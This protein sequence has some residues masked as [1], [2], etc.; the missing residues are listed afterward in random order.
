MRVEIKASLLALA[1]ASVAGCGSTTGA[2]GGPPIAEWNVEPISR[3]ER[4]DGGGRRSEGLLRPRTAN[5]RAL[6]AEGTGRFIGSSRGRSGPSDPVNEEGVTLN[7]ANLPIPQAAK[8]VVGDILGADFVVD[9]KLDGKVTIHTAN[10]VRKSAALDLFQSALRVAGASVVKSGT[11]Y[12]IVPSDQAAISGEVIT[13]DSTPLDAAQFGEGA[14]VVQLRYVSAAEMKRVLEPIA[15]RGAIVRADDA[16][17]TLTLTGAPQDLATLQDAI[18]MFDID[19]MK[20]MSFALVPVR[21]GDADLLADDL[22]NVFGSEKEGPMGGMIRFIGNKRLSSILVI[23]SQPQ[24]LARAR[25]W[26]EKLDARAEHAEKQFFTY[27]VQNRPAKELM[28]VLTSIFGAKGQG[29]SSVSPRFG[30]SSLSSGNGF[31]GGLGG[32]QGA[33]SP[34]GALS[35]SGPTSGVSGGGVASNGG[36]GGGG[37]MGGGLG[38]GGGLSGGVGSPSSISGFSVPGGAQN[39]AAQGPTP[40]VSMDNDRYKIGVDDAKNA[41]IVMATPEDYRRIRQVIE[42][43]DVLPNQVFLE[44]TIAEVS[45]N[46]TLRF[47]VRWF[48]QSHSN[49]FGFSSGAG[50]APAPNDLLG[51]NLL[52]APVGAVFPGFA[53]AFRA[54]NQQV[55]FNALN[56]IT[57]VNIISTPSLTVLDNR[58]AMLQVG[59]QIPVQTLTSVSAIGNTFNSVNYTNTGVILKITPHISESGR[60]MLELEQEVSNVDPN[61]A[62][63]S[64]TPTIQQRRVKTQVVVNDGES[65]M[66]GGLVKDQNG[67][68]SAQVP[69]AGDVPLVGNLFKDKGNTILKSEL[70]IM[71]TP[72]VVRSLS[73]GREI[74]EEYKRKLLNISTRAIGRPHDIEQSARR[75]F[76]DPWSKSPWRTDRET[77]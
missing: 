76:L 22:K 49:L 41:L 61:T 75:T 53:Y 48:M 52:G 33:T 55:T 40:A 60:V 7:L 58:E 26:I 29:E 63:G 62:A 51:S 27:R 16:R 15:A 11:I 19:T 9:P 6:V 65:L 39:G 3:S 54:L 36:L 74:T 14:R 42:T 37:G 24:Y 12:K 45:L 68:G 17:N 43:L 57:D 38:G 71:I 47:G 72:H 4:S 56:T 77:R 35:A 69:V 20:G 13:S 25:T 10:P 23:S 8:I 59:D 18:D 5:G 34:L 50:K 28:T 67:N 73:E 44:A 64:T 66:L 1:V 46:D 32:G 30:Q 2:G 70:V 21:S 31:G